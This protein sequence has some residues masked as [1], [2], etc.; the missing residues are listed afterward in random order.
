MNN[1]HEVDESAIADGEETRGQA[2]AKPSGDEPANDA[3]WVERAPKT[4]GR[5]AR[6]KGKPISAQGPFSQVA[7][8][9][10]HLLNASPFQPRRSQ[11]GVPGVGSARHQYDEFADRDGVDAPRYGDWEYSGRCTDF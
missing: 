11:P 10:V 3:P 9:F 8:Y 7:R 4:F 5:H 2:P 6:V 1:E